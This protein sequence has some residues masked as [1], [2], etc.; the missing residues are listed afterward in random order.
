MTPNAWLQIVLFFSAIGLLTAPL[1]RYMA[2]VYQGEHCCGTERA[3]GWLERCVYRIAAIDPKCE[4]SWHHYL[5]AAL[6]INGIGFLAVYAIL[7]LQGMLPWNPQQFSG[8]TPD[9][10]FNTA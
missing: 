2:K 6:A 4:M 7:R 8:A 3:L 5:K 10:A 1:G 9:L